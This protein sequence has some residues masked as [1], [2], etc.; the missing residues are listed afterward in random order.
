M[1]V[2]VSAAQPARTTPAAGASPGILDGNLIASAGY[3]AVN[4]VLQSLS[5]PG[6]GAR[7][8]RTDLTQP[9][10]AK[11]LD[12]AR[13]AVALLTSGSQT[14]SDNYLR[15]NASAAA[16]YAAQGVEHLTWVD[17]VVSN[18]KEPTQG[19]IDAAFRDAHAS[20]TE[21]EATQGW[22]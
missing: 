14:A 11:T 8:A 7:Q 9:E 6:S 17:D 4:G 10:L 2:A 19:M 12:L 1:S 18:H 21:A 15:R 13:D 3:A 5:V 20:F 16:E 22:E